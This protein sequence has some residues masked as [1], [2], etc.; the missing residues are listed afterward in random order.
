MKPEGPIVLS[1]MVTAR[2]LAEK[3]NVTAKD[4]LASQEA[5]MVGA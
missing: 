5:V 3:L 1:E 2:E 4:L